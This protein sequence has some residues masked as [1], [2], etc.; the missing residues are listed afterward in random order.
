M[1]ADRRGQSFAAGILLVTLFALITGAVYDVYNLTATRAWA[2]R[3]AGKAALAGVQVGRDYSYYMS[4]GDIALDAVTA[5]AAAADLAHHA[6][7]DRGLTGHT[8]EVEVLPWPGGGTVSGFP[9]V[10]RA[11]QFGGT[12]WTALEPSVGVYLAVPVHTVF[13]GLVN[14]GGP[15][16][17][18]VF[19]AAGVV[20][21]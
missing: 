19:A 17:V 13:F 16:M 1:I 8:L 10:G 6:L 15:V 20:K 18:H 7:S 11:N 12:S 3:A 5:E 4:T 14:D 21:R 9:P 2:Y